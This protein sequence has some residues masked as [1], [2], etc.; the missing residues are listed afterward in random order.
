M[1]KVQLGIVVEFS[2][3]QTISDFETGLKPALTASFPHIENEQNFKSCFF[4]HL[5]AVKRKLFSLHMQVL[6]NISIITT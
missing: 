3:T 4:H 6:F 2:F 5:Q 1:K